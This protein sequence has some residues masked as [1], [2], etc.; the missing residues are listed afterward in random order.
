MTGMET[1]STK[2]AADEDGGKTDVE[3]EAGRLIINS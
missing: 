1:T 3:W 2:T